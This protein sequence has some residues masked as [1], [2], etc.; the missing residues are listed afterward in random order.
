MADY[1]RRVRASIQR[2]WQKLLGIL[3]CVERLAGVEDQP[4]SC[5]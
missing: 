1:N 5:G 3:R 2:F 4:L